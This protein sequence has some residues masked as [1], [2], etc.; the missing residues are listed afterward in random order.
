MDACVG[1]LFAVDDEVLGF[2]G[3]EV[4]FPDLVVETVVVVLVESL[5][6]ADP[7]VKLLEVQPTSINHYRPVF[8]SILAYRNIF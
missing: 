3:A 7:V 8:M 1:G 4:C 5:M 6:D 2:V